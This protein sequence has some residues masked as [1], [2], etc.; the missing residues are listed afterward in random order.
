MEDFLVKSQAKGEFFLGSDLTAADF[1]MFF[2]LEAGIQHGSLNE[3][4]YPTLYNYVRRMQERAA[5]QQAGEKVTKAS[6]EKFV[7]F[8]E[9][10]M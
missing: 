6:G 2:A 3:E 5:Y 9:S 8:S 7:P 10:R 4:S 1:M